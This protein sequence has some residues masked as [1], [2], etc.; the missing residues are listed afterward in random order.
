MVSGA[1]PILHLDRFVGSPSARGLVNFSFHLGSRLRCAELADLDPA[2]IQEQT[3][4]R[5]VRKARWTRFGRDHRFDSICSV[6]DFQRAVPVRT[7]ECSGT[8]TCVM[9]IPSLTI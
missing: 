9:P 4:R 2:R 5:L 8:R 6:A 7:Y 3:L 1:E